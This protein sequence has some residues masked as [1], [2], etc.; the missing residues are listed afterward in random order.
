MTRVTCPVCRYSAEDEEFETAIRQAGYIAD[1]G[2]RCPSC[3]H[4]FGF[5]LF[6]SE[7]NR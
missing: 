6:K 1:V 7:M 4:E 2:Y 3:E 5:E